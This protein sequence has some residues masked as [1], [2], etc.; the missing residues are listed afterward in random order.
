MPRYLRIH[1]MRAGRILDDK[2]VSEDVLIGSHTLFEITRE[3]PVLHV[4]DSVI[5]ELALDGRT[6]RPLAA[7]IDEGEPTDSGWR[8][9][10]PESTRGWVQFGGLTFYVQLESKP[11]PIPAR[12]PREA[13]AGLFGGLQTGFLAV[14]LAVLS[15][16]GLGVFALHR[17][18]LL[19]NDPLPEEPWARVLS[20]PSTE[21]MS[22]PVAPEI[23]PTS[24]VG[25]HAARGP[26]SSPKLA[27]PRGRQVGQ[28]V[29]QEILRGLRGSWAGGGVLG[30]AADPTEDPEFKRAIEGISVP[31]VAN[32]GPVLVGRERAEP[33]RIVDERPIGFPGAEPRQRDRTKLV[34]ARPLQVPPIPEP[35]GPEPVPGQPLPEPDILRFLKSKLG[36]LR[37]CYEHELKVQPTLH[38]KLV[39]GVTISPD[40]RV[41]EFSFDFDSL[42]SEP[43][44]TCIEQRARLW[45]V[46]NQRHE[47]V[48][49]ALPIVFAPSN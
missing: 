36:V 20:F 5:G 29:A 48:S 27:E 18:P 7:L 41:S 28:S 16:E 38:G 44:T 32:G 39:M 1:V 2:L 21:P 26:S 24:G 19:E 31:G 4:T 17:Q 3:L 46:P 35:P 33:G 40:G 11:L 42:K 30:H 22:P 14:L 47:E 9:P 49:F 43:V 23:R 37:Q 25:P 13:R 8:L 6:P 10:L 15:V 45:R 12:L 34:P